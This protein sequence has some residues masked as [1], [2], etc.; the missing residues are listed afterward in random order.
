MKISIKKLNKDFKSFISQEIIL[1]GWIRS[2]RDLKEFGFIN[3]N[4]GSTLSGVQIVYDKELENFKE[5]AKFRIGSS[6]TVIGK[7]VESPKS[8]QA[9]EI[10]ASKI[11]LVGDSPENYPIQ[12]KRHTLEFLREHAHLRPR[13]N[14]FNAVFRVRSLLAFAIHEFFRREDFMYVHSPIITANDAEGAGELFHVTSLD[15]DN[16]PKTKD[17]KVDYS[18]DFFG[19]PVNL[20]VSGQLEAEIFA[21]A[22]KKVYTFGPTFRAENSNTTRHAAEFGMLEPEVCFADLNDIMD[23]IEDLLKYVINYIFKHAEEEMQFFD[24]FV[25]KGKIKQLQEF[26]NS[27]IVRLEYADAIE[28]FN[29]AKGK[30]SKPFE[31]GDGLGTEHEKYLTDEYFK[32][33]VFVVNWPKEIKSFYMRQNDDN[34]T[35]AA[36]DLLVPGAG[37]LVGGSQREERLDLL[38]NRM[39]E[40]NIP[41]KELDW[42]LD[43]R[44]Y[45]GAYHSGFG[46]GFARLIKY[47]TGVENIRDVIPFPRTP[48]NCEF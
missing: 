23:L 38:I 15:L 48:N 29:K 9:Y 20:T 30:F 18:K 13:T 5:I 4:D 17:N 41:I 26:L 25:Y 1:Q 12:P 10:K 45:G 7:V 36:V 35:V 42:Y 3:L 19:K 28:I 31:Y 8:Q 37:E 22:F 27:K 11:V 6:L 43:L 40:L 24:K 2:N 32:A 16:L 14:L 33:P 46:V 21:M 39:E 34:K 44:R 47:V